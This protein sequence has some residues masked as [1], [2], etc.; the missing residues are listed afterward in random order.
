MSYSGIS[1][2]QIN[3]YIDSADRSGISIMSMATCQQI[4][5][6]LAN[7]PK[8]SASSPDFCR[9]IQERPSMPVVKSAEVNAEVNQDGFVYIT[10]RKVPVEVV[11]LTESTIIHGALYADG[12]IASAGLSVSSAVSSI[13]GPLFASVI[14]EDMI[15]TPIDDLSDINSTTASEGVRRPVLD[16][17]VY[18]YPSGLDEEDVML[19]LFFGENDADS[20]SDSDGQGSSPDSNLNKLGSDSDDDSSPDSDLDE[21]VAML[22]NPGQTQGKG[23]LES[24]DIAPLSN[25]A[26]RRPDLN[27]YSEQKAATLG[28][29]APTPTPSGSGRRGRPQGLYPPRS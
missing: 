13:N 22:Y 3:D 19:S 20:D 25:D 15:M 14:A 28:S 1:S 9:L 23:Q 24:G 26:G 8:P 29:D 16:E 21:I 2:E 4:G 18:E 6:Y 27:L 17:V 5:N 11:E 10:F 12:S 7:Y